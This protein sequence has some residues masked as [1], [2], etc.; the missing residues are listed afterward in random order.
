MWQSCACHWVRQCSWWAPHKVPRTGDPSLPTC[1]PPTHTPSPSQVPTWSRCSD[2]LPPAQ[3][4]CSQHSFLPHQGAETSSEKMLP[5]LTPWL[6]LSPSSAAWFSNLI[7]HQNPLEGLLNQVPGP[8]PL[9]FLV[10]CALG[11][12]LRICIYK[13][14]Q[15]I[16]M[17][18]VIEGSHMENDWSEEKKQN[19]FSK[20]LTEQ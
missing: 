4:G 14:S 5:G 2:F 13:N 11:W 3:E 9:E 1:P 7:K 19:G 15:K 6:S 16:L 17:L 10:Q 18:L 8:H 20:K 12:S